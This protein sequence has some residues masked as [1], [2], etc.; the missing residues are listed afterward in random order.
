MTRD[1]VRDWPRHHARTTPGKLAH[2]DLASGRRF[3]YRDFD[4]RVG[5]AAGLMQSLGIKAGD[6]VG[7]LM[8]NSTDVLEIVFA[9]WRI[10]AIALALNWRLTADELD[11]I[12]NDAGARAVFLDTDSAELAADLRERTDVEHWIV[13]DGLG[14][15]SAYERGL[16]DHDPVFEMALQ[17]LPDQ[18]LLMYS[19]GTT[20]K[21]KGV[22]ITHEMMLFS[23][24]NLVQS[25]QLSSNSTSL[26]AMP[27][28]HIGGLNVFTCPLIYVG[29]AN[30]VM[31]AFDP[32]V[33]LDAFSDPAH[34]I[35]HFLGVPA[36]FNALKMHPQ[37]GEADFSRL[38]VAL[39]GAEAVPHSLIHWWN[40][41]GLKVQEGFGM[42]E[43]AA[44][45]CLLPAEYVPEM[46]GSAG[47]ATLHSE[48][49]IVRE[50]GS[51]A[52]AGELGE[53]WMRGPAITPG[54]WNR[55]EANEEC[56]VDG[57]FRSGD[58]AKIDADGFVFIEDRVKDMYISGGENVYPAEVEN[59]LYELD[60]IA[61]VA[62]I[63]VTDS[64]WGEVGC[65]VVA[66]KDGA[67]LSLADIARHCDD[68]LAKFKQPAH[69][70]LVD[71]L[72]RNATGKV[73]KFELRQS[74]PSQL[75]LR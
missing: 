56:F 1:I 67:A 68:R 59:I 31:R 42:T 5:R 71:I 46:A 50:D 64:Q 74:V 28:F 53:I 23:A 51:E 27:M 21:P 60:A 65:A 18:C 62:V 39:A 52:E 14:G 34:G 36:I 47:K 48:M 54:Y 20:G 75:E 58:I 13:S 73:L 41:R 63:G 10:G 69:L 45:N 70:A 40:E 3:A 24:I 26:V 43:S 16:A 19:S 8:F 17:Q 72:P 29:G 25:S 35:T 32:A 61:E 6:R 38:E 37:N 33:A 55:P 44:S 66:L 2:V 12:V 22:I 30:I 9:C 4:D 49:K 11:F 15:D 57:W 7:Y